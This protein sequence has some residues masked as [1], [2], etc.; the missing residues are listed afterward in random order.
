MADET[1][2]VDIIVSAKD[3]A[4]GA[5]GKL[6][7]QFR[8]LA[9]VIGRAAKVGVVALAGLAAGAAKLAL[10]A[11]KIQQVRNAFNALTADM[12]GGANKILNSLTDSAA[13]LI[14]QADAMKSFNLAAG[15]ISKQFAEELPS[16]MG[17]LTKVA[18]ATGESMDFL[19]D[20][21]VRGVGRLSPLILDNLGIQVDLTKAYED[22]ADANGLVATELTKNQQQQALFAQVQ[23]KLLE[24]TKDLPPVVGTAA[25]AWGAFTT[26]MRNFK[27]Q[28]GLALLPIFAPILQSLAK[29]AQ[30]A[31]PQ[32]ISR[33]QEFAP[34]LAKVGEFIAF[35]IEDFDLLAAAEIL[36]EEWQDEAIALANAIATVS[37]WISTL[38]G[39]IQ[40]F[41]STHG[42]ALTTALKL[43][44]GAFALWAIITVISG[45]LSAL[46]GPMGLLVIA[47]TILGFAWENN[48]FGIRDILTNVWENHLRP[49]LEDLWAWLK[50]KVPEAI[51]S[52]RAWWEEHWP[53]IRE[54]LI[55]AWEEH[56]RPALI[57]LKD[58]LEVTIPAAVDKIRSWFEENWPKIK[59]AVLDAWENH[60]RPA[61]EDIQTFLDTTLPNAID[62]AV[63]WWREEFLPAAEDV[64]EYLTGP[65]TDMM[66][67]LNDLIETILVKSFENWAFAIE[68]IKTAAEPVWEWL[69]NTFGPL[70]ENELFKAVDKLTNSGIVPLS[71]G[72]DGLRKAT[73]K[74]TG[75]LQDLKTLIQNFPSLPEWAMGQSP[76]PIE[77]AFR[78]WADA[79]SEVTKAGKTLGT[80]NLSG[81][82]G[83]GSLAGAGVMSSVGG[84]V[85]IGEI[86]VQAAPGMNERQLADEVVERVIDEIATRRRRFFRG[87]GR[88]AGS[89]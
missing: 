59:E 77:L 82:M 54:A 10:D 84:D 89:V 85:S 22:F 79:I 9:G 86:V 23:E 71:S 6:N 35:L 16:A 67:A 21:L 56:I 19:L 12:E 13:G 36:P 8:T 73:E 43:V 3:R 34:L 24:N 62:K 1:L 18:A 26:S 27:D 63:S 44:A 75:W 88:Y 41:V 64:W 30:E 5:L 48:W 14:T 15:L 53:A 11:S 80:M 78:G 58:W 57:D 33:L 69:K 47:A 66:N 60:I 81:H 39:W 76:S 28:V 17:P 7:N 38:S 55:I 29:L 87:G 31:F 2:A 70:L 4:S 32:I 46:L 51:A 37:G 83:M 72:L 40:G 74:V 25:Q 68:A 52:L 65:F 50:V 49:K 42:P 45:L 20:S 61:L